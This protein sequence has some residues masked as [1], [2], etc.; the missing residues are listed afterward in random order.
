MPSG[1]SYPASSAI[2]VL[3]PRETPIHAACA[4]RE[5]A[6]SLTLFDAKDDRIAVNSLRPNIS[7]NT[8]P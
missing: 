3:K 6:A 5:C 1:A 4:G 7:R 8:P 2:L